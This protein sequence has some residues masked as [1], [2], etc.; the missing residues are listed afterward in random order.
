MPARDRKAGCSWSRHRT[1]ATGRPALGSGLR[2]WWQ[3]WADY[4][5][6]LYSEGWYP[7]V[8]AAR[9]LIR[10]APE[11]AVDQLSLPVEPARWPLDVECIPPFEPFRDAGDRALI[12]T[13][14][15]AGVPTIL[16][17]DLNSF[18]R[19]RRALYP[20]GIEIWRPTDL[21]KTLLRDAAS[22]GLTT[23]LT[24]RTAPVATLARER[25]VRNRRCQE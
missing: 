4:F 2:E 17:T 11:V 6:G 15:R 5:D 13:A 12:R 1:T 21:W 7:H 9:L 22:R 24:T 23:P 18:W 16:T 25:S 19:Y 8:D 14:V 20:L 10:N 3:Q